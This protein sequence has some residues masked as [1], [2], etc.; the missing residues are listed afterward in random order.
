MSLIE[1][2]LRK[3]EQNGVRRPGLA[4]P[5]APPPVPVGVAAHPA[6]RRSNR[7]RKLAIA[8]VGMLA[9]AFLGLVVF[10]RLVREKPVART[11]PSALAGVLRP[12]SARM[13][14][15]TSAVPVALPEGPPHVS[16]AT[17]EASP[18]ARARAPTLATPVADTPAA[19]VLTNPPPAAG[20]TWP[21]I[22]LKGTFAAGGKMFA[23]FGDGNSLE[24]GST[25][26]SGVKVIE[27][28]PAAVRVSYRGETRI[29]RRGGGQFVA[30][31]NADS[32]TPP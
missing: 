22:V 18:V 31:T 27:A 10:P 32:L 30:V 9:L 1:E 4:G 19:T 11:T 26:T 28:T 6:V 15:A 16:P 8:G 24:T 23:I 7:A 3:Q 2:A 14:V 17:N 12:A 13:A 25:A 5:L 20:V 21:E 29:Y